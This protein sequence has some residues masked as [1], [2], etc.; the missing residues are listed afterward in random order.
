MSLDK[1]TAVLLEAP[2]QYLDH[3]FLALGVEAEASFEKKLVDRIK[4]RT[5]Q[6]GPFGVLGFLRVVDRTL[7]RLLDTNPY[8]V[9]DLFERCLSALPKASLRGTPGADLFRREPRE[10]SSRHR[11]EDPH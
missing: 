2:D 3:L 9:R 5:K 4:M 8:F 6:L 10:M 1:D 7:P 11:P